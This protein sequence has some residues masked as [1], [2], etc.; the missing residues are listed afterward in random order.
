MLQ[1]HLVL[2]LENKKKQSFSKW[3]PSPRIHEHIKTTCQ[4]AALRKWS[5]SFISS[6]R[7]VFNKLESTK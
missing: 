7:I 4:E 2:V 3:Q 6:S 5:T 1:E